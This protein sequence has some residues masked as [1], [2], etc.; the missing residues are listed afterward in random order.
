MTSVTCDHPPDFFHDPVFHRVIWKK[1]KYFFYFYP[2]GSDLTQIKN[3]QMTTTNYW[4]A[5]ALATSAYVSPVKHE[6]GIKLTEE[7]RNN[8]ANHHK[9]GLCCCCDAGLDD[10]TDFVCVDILDDDNGFALMCNACDDYYS[11][12]DN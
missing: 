7:Q 10:R 2:D 6:P 3:E 8:K 5:T 12:Q 1:L 11:Q 9:Y 4:T